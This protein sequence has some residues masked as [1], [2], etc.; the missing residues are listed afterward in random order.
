MDI[1]W[2]VIPLTFLTGF[3][4][5]KKVHGTVGMAVSAALG[6]LVY[7]LGLFLI[8]G[9]SAVFTFDIFTQLLMVAFGALTAIF[10]WF[11][12]ENIKL[13]TLRKTKKENKLET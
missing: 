13:P 12:G 1:S 2:L 11:I 8:A 4:L 7:V 5:G 10:G 3:V 6:A 9:P